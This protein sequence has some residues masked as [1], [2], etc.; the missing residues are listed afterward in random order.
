[1]KRYLILLVVAVT[2][3][4]GCALLDNVLFDKEVVTEEQ[5]ITGPEGLVTNTVISTN[6]IASPKIEAATKFTTLIPLPYADLIG[7]ALA[8][9]L[10]VAANL[11][12]KKIK[13]A[14]VE[15]TNEV[16]Q[17]CDEVG[18]LDKAKDKLKESQVAAGVRDSVK[19]ILVK[20]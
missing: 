18:M 20:L 2:C 13:K 5:V 3:F 11:R 9:A 8:G 15:G 7:V 14:L 17:L 10:G 4:T 12:N 6:Y 1:M 19:Q 16:L